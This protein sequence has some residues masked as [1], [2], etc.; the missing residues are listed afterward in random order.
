MH[1]SVPEK[2]NL[3][4]SMVVLPAGMLYHRNSTWNFPKRC[5]MTWHM[6]SVL[7]YLTA[8]LQKSR[9]S[10][11]PSSIEVAQLNT[12]K[13]GV[14]AF[15]DFYQENSLEPPV[16][17]PNKDNDATIWLGKATGADTVVERALESSTCSG[18]KATTLAGKL[19]AYIHSILTSLKEWFSITRIQRRVN[20]ICFGSPLRN[21]SGL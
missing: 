1:C 13:G 7:R 6:R 15:S 2:K 5:D 18:V 20:R 3:L 11:R 14:A 19:S 16:L 9:M 4:K 17:L 21:I 12:V 8:F 10:L